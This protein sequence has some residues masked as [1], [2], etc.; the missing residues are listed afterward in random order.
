MDAAKVSDDKEIKLRVQQE[1]GLAIY[2]DNSYKGERI[3]KK[4]GFAST[5]IYDGTHGYGL[6]NVKNSVKK[7][8]G[9]VMEY[10]DENKFYV[11]VYIP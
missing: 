9:N 3:K 5:K 6:N 8:G 11:S 1:T 2:I 4:E 7:Y 10:C